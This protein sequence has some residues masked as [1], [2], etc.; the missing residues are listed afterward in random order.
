MIP[1][2]MEQAAM[3]L[4]PSRPRYVMHAAELHDR[5]GQ[6]EE[7]RALRSELRTRWHEYAEMLLRQEVDSEIEVPL[8]PIGATDSSSGFTQVLP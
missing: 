7:A 2:G 1:L 3:R 8:E 5:L 4:D 6:T